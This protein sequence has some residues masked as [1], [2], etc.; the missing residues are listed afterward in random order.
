MKRAMAGGCDVADSRRSF[1]AVVEHGSG[2]LPTPHLHPI[3][4]LTTPASTPLAATASSRVTCTDLSQLGTS[5]SPPFLL[6][7]YPG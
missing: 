2:T 4:S 7:L 1:A 6:S 3:P 5:P